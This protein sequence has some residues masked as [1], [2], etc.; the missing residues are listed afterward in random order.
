MNVKLKS[1]KRQADL[2]LEGH[3]FRLQS[4][5]WCDMYDNE[6][7]LSYARLKGGVVST[8]VYHI[9]NDAVCYWAEKSRVWLSMLERLFMDRTVSLLEHLKDKSD[10]EIFCYFFQKKSILLHNSVFKFVNVLREKN[11]KFKLCNSCKV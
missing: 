11:L 5:I 6:V 1:F 8:Y 7:K 2:C 3:I 10:Y 4:N 9:N